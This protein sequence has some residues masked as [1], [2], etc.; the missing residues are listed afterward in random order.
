MTDKT[1]VKKRPPGATGNVIAMTW[2]PQ[3]YPQ[4][5]GYMQLTHFWLATTPKAGF[6]THHIIKFYH[7]YMYFRSK[8]NPFKLKR[9]SMQKC[10]SS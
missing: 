4:Y 6:N 1:Y 9:L 8:L 2:S 5:R 3:N 7:I 10:G